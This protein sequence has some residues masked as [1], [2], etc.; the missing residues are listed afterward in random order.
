MTG[1]SKLL[2]GRKGSRNTLYIGVQL[3]GNESLGTVL[4]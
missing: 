2:V 4:S 1:K 3:G